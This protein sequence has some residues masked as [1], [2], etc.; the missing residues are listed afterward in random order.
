LLV[1]L[2]GWFS[3]EA[4]NCAPHPTVGNGRDFRPGRH[5]LKTWSTH[6]HQLHPVGVPDPEG[7]QHSKL[8][9]GSVTIRSIASH[10]L[11]WRGGYWFIYM[12]YHERICV[13]L[14]V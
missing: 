5:C 4:V 9:L 3:G 12:A 7:F 2:G 1:H 11:K 8:W 6:D 10:T 13:N 14:Q